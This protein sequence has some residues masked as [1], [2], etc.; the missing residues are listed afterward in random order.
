M[1]LPIYR[2]LSS[3]ALTSA[4][5][6]LCFAA[7]ANAAEAW[8]CFDEACFPTAFHGDATGH[9]VKVTDWSVGGFSGHTKAQVRE[10]GNHVC[11]AASHNLPAACESAEAPTKVCAAANPQTTCGEGTVLNDEGTQCVVE[12][13]MPEVSCGPGTILVEDTCLVDT[14]GSR[15]ETAAFDMGVAWVCHGQGACFPTAFEGDAT[16]EVIQ[17]SDWSV[18]DW[19][20]LTKQQVL[21]AGDYACTKPSFDQAATCERHFAEVPSGACACLEQFGVLAGN[22]EDTGIDGNKDLPFVVQIPNGNGQYTSPVSVAFACYNIAYANSQNKY[23]ETTSNRQIDAYRRGLDFYGV[24]RINRADRYE[25]LPRHEAAKLV[26][27]RPD[28]KGIA[29]SAQ[30]CSTPIQNDILES[31]YQRYRSN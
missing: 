11:T 31:F 7:Q 10:D 19:A 27:T 8:L 23:P 26:V 5:L 2:S 12:F 20:G 4:V 3:A 25:E 29:C 15:E 17:I 1:T 16:G 30:S 21:E 13:Q 18:N 9:V 24:T 22:C 14:E 6:A 28:F